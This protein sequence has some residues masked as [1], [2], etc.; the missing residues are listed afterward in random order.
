MLR[1]IFFKKFSL[2][3]ENHK[4]FIKNGLPPV[5]F[6]LLRNK[7]SPLE[8][9]LSLSILKN[10]TKNNFEIQDNFR[11]LGLIEL[12]QPLRSLGSS[13]IEELASDLLD[14]LDAWV[15]ELKKGK[16]KEICIIL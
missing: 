10:L 13:D 3:S 2:R 4:G 16:S 8:I 1:L 12:L 7:K 11:Q 14:N 5:L 15:P 6:E 9:K